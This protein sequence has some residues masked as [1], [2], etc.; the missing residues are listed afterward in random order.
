MG[1]S[2]ILRS[3]FFLDLGLSKYFGHLMW[4]DLMVLRG[5]RYRECRSIRSAQAAQ[6]VRCPVMSRGSSPGHRLG[7]NDP[8]GRRRA[9]VGCSTARAVGSCREGIRRSRAMGVSGKRWIWS[10]ALLVDSAFEGDREGVQRGLLPCDSACPPQ[11]VGSSDRVTG[12]RHLSAG[13][14]LGKCPR[15]VTAR[16]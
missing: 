8:R 2:W 14:R 6:E 16:R 5:R 13:A 9:R 3:R 11:A 10:G 15:A 12:C 4:Q 1:L 7:S